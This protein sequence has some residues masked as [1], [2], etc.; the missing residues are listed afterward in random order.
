MWFGFDIEVVNVLEDPAL[1]AAYAEAVPQAFVGDRLACKF[2]MDPAR[3]ARLLSESGAG[4][5]R[6]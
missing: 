5:P 2:R 3:F 6:D 1:A 4:R